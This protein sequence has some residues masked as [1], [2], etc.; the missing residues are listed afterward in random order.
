MHVIGFSYRCKILIMFPLLSK[1]K[2]VKIEIHFI[3]LLLRMMHVIGF[4]KSCYHAEACDWALRQM[5]VIR[6]SGRC[7]WLS[8]QADA[9]D[10]VLS[11]KYVIA[12]SDRYMWLGSQRDWSVW[13]LRQMQV[14]GFK[15][16]SKE[17]SETICGRL[18]LSVCIFF[19]CKDYTGI[20]ELYSASWMPLNCLRNAV[21]A[22]CKYS[23]DIW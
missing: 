5:R 11:Q 15:C 1:L 3:G 10:S 20:V 18:P 8:S 13:V 17:L 9:C 23:D 19:F 12:F 21:A 16:P 4:S 14:I 7:K 6:F 2:T 22:F